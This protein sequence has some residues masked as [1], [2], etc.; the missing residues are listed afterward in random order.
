MK[1]LTSAGLLFA[2][3]NSTSVDGNSGAYTMVDWAAIFNEIHLSEKTTTNKFTEPDTVTIG[4]MPNVMSLLTAYDGGKYMVGYSTFDNMT[5]FGWTMKLW[6]TLGLTTA[7][8]AG[9]KPAGYIVFVTKP[10]NV[11][12]TTTS[13]CNTNTQWLYVNPGPAA[14]GTIASFRYTSINLA[15]AEDWVSS[16]SH[17]K[18]YI[19]G[20]IENLA[21]YGLGQYRA[22]L[23]G[24]DYDGVVINLT[25]DFPAGIPETVHK[26]SK[27]GTDTWSGMENATNGCVTAMD[28][29]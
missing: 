14:A 19:G 2:A 12:G 17:P 9:S 21:S 5:T 18:V 16:V 1:L 6:G 25:D 24:L 8:T 27:L 15:V 28:G 20:G 26:V 4:L 22:Y 29:G 7:C 23:F 3:V 13:A 11:T 10:F